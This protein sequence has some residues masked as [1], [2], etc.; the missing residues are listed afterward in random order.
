MTNALD[1]LLPGPSGPSEGVTLR[2]GVVTQV[3]PLMVRLERDADPSYVNATCVAVDAL[4]AQFGTPVLVAKSGD[5]LILTNR[6]G[7]P[8]R[9]GMLRYYAGSDIPAGYLDCD[10]SM[11]PIADYPR[12]FARIGTQFGGDGVATFGLP[13]ARGR[14][15]AGVWPGSTNFD[16]VG[17]M[18]GDEMVTLTAAQSGLPNHTHQLPGGSGAGVATDTDSVARSTTTYANADKNFRTGYPSSGTAYNSPLIGGSSASQAHSNL[19]PY[20]VT[21]VLIKT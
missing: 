15:I 4:D 12:L 18:G 8:D 5:R 10:G 21:R 16:H 1:V 3:S 13:N 2:F 9:P 7:D 14:V 17:T 11:K 20:I 6:L 19:A